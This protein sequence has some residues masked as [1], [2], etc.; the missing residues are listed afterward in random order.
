MKTTSASKSPAPPPLMT[1]PEVARRLG[2]CRATV[3]RWVNSGR[4]PGSKVGP[5]TWRF[6]EANIQEFLIQTSNQRATAEVTER[7]RA[8]AQKARKAVMAGRGKRRKLN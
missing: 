7:A 2:V 3:W 5:N 4:L 8:A 6:S 1:I